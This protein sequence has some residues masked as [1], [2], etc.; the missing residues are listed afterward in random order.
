MIQTY[1]V[2]ANL[3]IT[4]SSSFVTNF[5]ISTTNF[6]PVFTGTTMTGTNQ[7]DPAYP[8]EKRYDGGPWR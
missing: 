3:P 7:F 5:V 1:G 6:P 2:I 8:P 4:G